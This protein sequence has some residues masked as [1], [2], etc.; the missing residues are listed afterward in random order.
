MPRASKST[1]DV[2]PAARPGF[3][4]NALVEGG[5]DIEVIKPD[6]NFQKLV[7]DENFMYEELEVRFHE[8]GDA[9]APKMVEVGVGIPGK[10]YRKGFLRGK[11]YKVPRFMVEVFAHAKV[12]SLEQ[13]PGPSGRPEDIVNVEKH[14]FFYP[15]EV[16]HDPNPKGRAWL[17]KVLADP[18]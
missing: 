7:E 15:F 11:I 18:A 1:H 9:N 12:T 8:T 2:R 13:K 10:D 5:S 17:E 16:L 14:A 3:D 4:L 6:R